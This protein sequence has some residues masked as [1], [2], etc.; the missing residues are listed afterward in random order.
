MI[1]EAKYTAVKKSDVLT[2]IIH[3]GYTEQQLNKCLE[4]FDSYNVL[5][6]GEDGETIRYVQKV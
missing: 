1:V 6:V 4:E 2:R 3:K 5:S